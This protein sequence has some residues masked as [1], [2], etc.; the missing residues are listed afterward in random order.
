MDGQTFSG[1][2]INGV[3]QSAKKRNVPIAAFCGSIDVTIEEMQKMGLDYAVSIL[4]QVGNLD[5][6]KARSAKNLEL[7]SYNFAHLVKLSR[8]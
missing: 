2:T 4:N 7:A 1:K 5:E 6:A 8:S 3:V